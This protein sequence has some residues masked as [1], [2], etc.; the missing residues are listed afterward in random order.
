MVYQYRVKGLQKVPAQVAG[1]VCEWLENSEQGLSPRTLL[2]ASRDA[3]A[4]LHNEFEWNDSEAAER[5][6][7]QQAG[8]IIRNLYIVSAE[9]REEDTARAFVSVHTEQKQGTYHN[10]KVVLDNEAMREKLFASAKRDMQ[11]FIAKY[12]TLEVLSNVIAEMQ[13]VS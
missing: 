2:D 7:E 10:L 4:P 8:S 11:S 9:R 12:K 3:N 5:Y 1:E 13:L 6:R